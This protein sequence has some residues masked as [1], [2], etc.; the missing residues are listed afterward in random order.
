MKTGRVIVFNFVAFQALW[1][2][3]VLSAKPGLE[4]A[5]LLIV[6]LYTLTHLHWV[7]S[8]QQALPLLITALLGC[9]MDQAGYAM[10]WISFPYPH[11]WNSYMPLWMIALWTAFATTLNVSMRWLQ[12]KPGLAALLGSVFGPL[13]YLG[14]EQLGVISLPSPTT[15]LTWVAVEWAVA[16]PL[17]L[18]IRVTFNQSNQMRPA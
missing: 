4:L 5:I 18:W 15:S 3:C 7:E 9:V 11:P 14:A 12:G 8:W 1:W 17:M 2:A 13:A 10:G 6:L 16:M